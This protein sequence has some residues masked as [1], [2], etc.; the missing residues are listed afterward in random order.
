[1]FPKE[2][3]FPASGL[4]APPQIVSRGGALADRELAVVLAHSMPDTS[5]SA[6]LSIC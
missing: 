1:M 3:G 2:P 5:V 4:A 6:E